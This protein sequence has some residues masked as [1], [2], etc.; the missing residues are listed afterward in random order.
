MTLP[1]PLDHDGVFDGVMDLY[2]PNEFELDEAWNRGVRAIIHRASIGTRADTVPDRYLSRRQRARV[3][4]MLWG[5]FHFL[6]QDPVSDQVDKFLSI[7]DGADPA[8]LMAV[9][10]EGDH[11]PSYQ[12]LLA[13][14]KEFSNRLRFHPVL[15]AGNLV[16]EQREILRGDAVLT[17]CPLWYARYDTE[18]EG[19][20]DIPTSTWPTYTLWQFCSEHR[21]FGKPFAPEVLKGADFSRFRGSS[22]ELAA[23][24]PF[25]GASRGEEPE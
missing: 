7:E 10:W 24:W 16:R 22:K 21:H 3:K 19:K 5:A 11:P 8:T 25:R 18:D 23:A 2:G 4:G 13:F 6:T 12:T 20:L 14:V 1:S 17:M 9:D 15:Y